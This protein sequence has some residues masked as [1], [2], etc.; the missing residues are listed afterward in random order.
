MTGIVFLP[1]TKTPAAAMA[2]LRLAELSDSTKKMAERLKDYPY[3]L[4]AQKQ[5]NNFL[6]QPERNDRQKNIL[7]SEP[8]TNIA[9]KKVSF[10]YEGKKLVLK[11]L[12]Y[13]FKKGKINYLTGANGSGKSTIISLIMGLY[14]PQH[15][16]IFINNKYKLQEINLIVWREK[17][18]YA[19]HNNLVENGLSTGQKQLTDLNELFATSGKKE[20]FIFDEADNALDEN[21]KKDGKK[22]TKAEKILEDIEAQLK[23]LVTEKKE[24]KK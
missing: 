14:Q 17:I 10:A 21:N 3:G 13:E 7:I 11:K 1:F 5:I 20:I 15:G 12:N 9:L 16:E 22:K 23:K 6:T 2:V 19:E 24:L 4:S 8:I 18:A